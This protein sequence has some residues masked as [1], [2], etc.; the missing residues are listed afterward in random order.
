VGR[1][2][3]AKHA[4]FDDFF[5]FDYPR[6]VGALTLMTGDADLARDSVDEAVA[7]A[8]EQV[9]RG[10]AIENLPGWTRTVALNV[11]RGRFRRRTTERAARGRLCIG[12][13]S[14]GQDR[15][16]IALD[17]RRALETLPTRQREVTVLFYFLDLSVGEI[18]VELEVAEGTVKTSLHR[19]R[20]ALA[21]LLG[22]EV[23]ETAEEVRV[24]V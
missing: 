8:W 16:N 22:D 13:S 19:A 20:I 11:A 24:E 21:S 17:V 14:D 1:R 7:R 9:G 10:R 18:A 5:A 23:I 15:A 3:N 6:L 12:P 4:V 2:V